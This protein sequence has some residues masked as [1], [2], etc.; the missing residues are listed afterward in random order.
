MVRQAAMKTKMAWKT[1][2]TTLHFWIYDCGIRMLS[3]SACVQILKMLV[4]V[5][6]RG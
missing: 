3:L 4:C 5:E 1:C 2:A 6:G